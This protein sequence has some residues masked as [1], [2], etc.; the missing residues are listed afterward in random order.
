[1]N[2]TI[3]HY[4]LDATIPPFLFW[5][6]DRDVELAD[7]WLLFLRSTTRR[8]YVIKKKF[9][10]FRLSCGVFFMA[11]REFMPMTMPEAQNDYGLLTMCILKDMT[12][13]ALH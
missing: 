1:M 10:Y 2:V 7:S 6:V 5:P 13:S 3:K 8:Y 12:F 4:A 9:S 11:G